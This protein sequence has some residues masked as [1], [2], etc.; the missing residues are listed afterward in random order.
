MRVLRPGRKSNDDLAISTAR[1]RGS[2]L[3]SFTFESA[4]QEVAAY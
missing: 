3:E 1:N 2:I 4:M